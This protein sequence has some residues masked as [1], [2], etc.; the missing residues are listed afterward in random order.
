MAEMTYDARH[1]AL[2]VEEHGQALAVERVARH[3]GNQF[4][5]HAYE[6]TE[7]E[8]GVYRLD[9][10]LCAQ[11]TYGRYKQ[12]CVDE[13]HSVLRRKSAVGGVEN[14]RAQTG[15]GPGGDMVGQ[16][17]TAEAYRIAQQPQGDEKVVVDN[18]AGLQL[19]RRNGLCYVHGARLILQLC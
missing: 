16:N 5:H 10:E 17:E 1:E 8:H 12:H 15:N 4:L 11:H 6:D 2:V 13:Q 19:Q 9:E 14:Q 3:V 7:H 18:L